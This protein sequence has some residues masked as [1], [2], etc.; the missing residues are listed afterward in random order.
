MFQKQKTF[1]KKYSKVY[2]EIMARIAQRCVEMLGEPPCKFSLAGMGSLA[3]KEITP[4]SDFEHI[5]LLKNQTN[6]ENNLEYFRWYSV[7]FHLI[8]L[9]L[10]ETIVP[11]LDIYGL[12]DPDNNHKSW[13]FD[14]FTP[15]GISFDG[16]M[17][18]ACKFPLG[19]RTETKEKPFSTELI[20][21][22]EEML[23]YL[24]SEEDLKQGY[25]LKDIL[26]KNM[27]CVWR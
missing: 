21:P 25:H 10:Q 14:N 2:T 17:P 11:S 9:N 19:R 1:R 3:R 20:K 5:I 7:I 23:R 13:F 24:T 18:H 15:H 6:Y 12:N 4:Y 27:F 22:I 16:M 8:V 26:D